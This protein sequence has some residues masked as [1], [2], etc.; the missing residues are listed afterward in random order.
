[1]KRKTKKIHIVL[2]SLAVLIT[3]LISAGAYTIY[4]DFYKN[5]EH[6]S[7]SYDNKYTLVEEITKNGFM[8]AATSKFHIINNGTKETVYDCNNFYRTIDLWGV[9]FGEKN[10][11]VW[12][13][14][15][16]VGSR[17]YRYMNNNWIEY[18]ATGEYTGVE[19]ICTL[20]Y[21]KGDAIYQNITIEIPAVQ[22]P[23]KVKDYFIRIS[24]L[25]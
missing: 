14:S 23:Q 9:M 13:L 2:I 3:G 18:A 7:L 24:N 21:C 15:S 22:I 20:E 12:V 10:Y 1:M 8:K 16:D 6:K 25:G 4:H 17:C 11:D 19:K 5:E